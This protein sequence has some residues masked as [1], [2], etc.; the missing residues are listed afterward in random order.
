MSCSDDAGSVL[1]S[2]L[3]TPIPTPAPAPVVL[4]EDCAALTAL[5]AEDDH[6]AALVPVLCPEHPLDAVAARKALLAADSAD[7]ARRRIPLLTEF[8]ELAALAKLVAQVDVDV[9]ID[10][11][12]PSPAT[13]IVTPLSDTVL[14]TAALARSQ[15]RAPGLG[16]EA[17]TRARGYLA[18]V[19]T[20][21]LR[22][23]GIETTRPPGPLGRQL[24]A[25]AIHYG[26]AFCTA[27]WRRRVPGL[28]TLFNE[29]ERSILRAV[30]VLEADASVGDPPL[31]A[32]ELSMGRQYLERPDVNKR[33]LR[34]HERD[35]GLLSPTRVEPIAKAIPRLL[36][37]GLVDLAIARALTLRK[38]GNVAL[39]DID[40]LLRRGLTDAEGEEYLERLDTRLKR[41]RAASRSAPPAALDHAADPNWPSASVVAR[42]QLEA[43]EGAPSPFARRYA[44]GRA[45]LV[46]RAR[47]DALRVAIDRA[48][49]S[50]HPA[51]A[52]ALPLLRSV[53]DELD[54]GRLAWLRRKAATDGRVVTD[55]EAA[56]RRQFAAMAREAGDA[57]R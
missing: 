32:Y 30:L 55:P 15:V 8:P 18:K 56:T 10:A 21:A 2:A 25:L 42:E 31:V 17:R 34:A 33:L 35:L 11:R 40:Q 51:I 47:P 37:H 49:N 1:Q 53:L 3:S 39:A 5:A 57:A 16:S 48:G 20:H 27:Y 43:L 26:R 52:T 14:A 22:Q 7:A 6:A 23:L 54:D 28:G 29:T 44:L 45:V 13:A 12:L 41:A 50:T 36:E 9:E 19:H 24:A 46:F 38:R 4:P